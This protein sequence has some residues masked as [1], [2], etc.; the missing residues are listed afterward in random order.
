DA[1]SAPSVHSGLGFS[2]V[3]ATSTIAA[4][5]TTIRFGTILLSRSIALSTTT[6]TQKN[7]ARK[8]SPLRPN[9]TKQPATS[10]AVASSTNGETALLRTTHTPDG[11]ATQSRERPDRA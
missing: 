3:C 11:S 10:A 7:E 1:P 6:T 2:A 9:L 4:A 5:G 8:A